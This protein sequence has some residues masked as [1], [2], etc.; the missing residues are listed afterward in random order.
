LPQKL[1]QLSVTLT[2]SEGDPFEYG[3]SI[4]TVLA[5]NMISVG[6]DVP[7]LGLMVVNGQPKTTAEFIQASSRVGRGIPGLVVTL[8]NFG[9]ARDLSH[10]EH[11]RA[12][13]SALYRNVEATSVT[14]WAPRARDKALHAIVISVLRHLIAGLTGDEDAVNFDPQDPQVQS[15][16]NVILK[17]VQASSNLELADTQLDLLAIVNEWG[18]RSREMRN[19]SRRLRYWEK[20]APF[21]K[22]APHLMCSA[23]DGKRLSGGSLAWPTPGSL[24]DVEP[25]AAFILKSFVYPRREET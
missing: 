11:Y 2:Q 5:S 19:A 6:V 7:R 12:Y 14:P 4:D 1:H 16:M 17:R 18:R 13:H 23:E 10:F 15:L 20:K 24:R 21:G 3:R 9:R 8:Y 22:A 25:S